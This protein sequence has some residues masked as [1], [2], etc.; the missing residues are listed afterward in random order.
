MFR[1][2]KKPIAYVESNYQVNTRQARRVKQERLENSMQYAKLLISVLCV[3][4]MLALAAPLMSQTNPQSEKPSEQLASPEEERILKLL[5]QM[6]S[7]PQTIEPTDY[8]QTIYEDLQYAGGMAVRLKSDRIVQAIVD[9]PVHD[10][11]VGEAKMWALASFKDNPAAHACVV[12]ALQ[13]PEPKIQKNAAHVLFSWGEWE[14]AVPMIHRCGEYWM[15]GVSKSHLDP[16]V[17]PI[18]QEGARTS[19]SWEGRGQAAFYLQFFG[20][21]LTSIEVALD[22]VAHAPRDVDDNSI[23]RAKYTAL[24]TLARYHATDNVTDVARLADDP[25]ALVRI[26]VVDILQLYAYNGIEEARRALER[27]A[28][29][30]AD[31]NLRETAKA[32]LSKI[33]S[34]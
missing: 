6:N 18:L 5:Q 23:A 28:Q 30:N 29:E 15:L 14:L 12:E 10:P 11:D 26:Q 24:R 22:I 1:C 33:G 13:N 27:I 31:L 2:L 17:V 9:F 20:D 3:G 21:S 8:I 32:A 25:S 19:P 4:V 7:W 34:R 16:R